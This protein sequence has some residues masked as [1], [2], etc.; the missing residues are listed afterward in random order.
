MIGWYMI[1]AAKN[2]KVE[3]NDRKVRKATIL[4]QTLV[5]Q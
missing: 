4:E 3:I 2:K 1:A 5:L